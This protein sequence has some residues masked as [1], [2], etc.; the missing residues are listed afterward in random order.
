MTLGWKNWQEPRICNV[1]KPNW[2]PDRDDRVG[3]GCIDKCPGD[4]ATARALNDHFRLEGH[5]GSGFT[6]NSPYAV[7]ETRMSHEMVDGTR[8]P[9]NPE[10]G[11]DMTDL[12]HPNTGNGLAGSSDG[13]L[14]PEWRFEGAR[15]MDAGE[16]GGV[17]ITTMKFRF[18][19]GTP[20]PQTITINGVD[21]T[22]SDWKLTQI[23]PNAFEWVPLP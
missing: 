15:Q 1:C 5:P 2:D 9:R 11:G 12:V 19:D 16:A 13:H 10:Y 8:V 18:D 14:T 3:N 23:G 4:G 6:N 17:P 7:L 20:Y 21:V 22:A